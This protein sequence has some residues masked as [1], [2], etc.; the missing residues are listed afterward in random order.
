MDGDGDESSLPRRLVGLQPSLQGVYLARLVLDQPD[1]PACL[2]RVRV[3]VLGGGSWSEP[4]LGDQLPTPSSL[5]FQ[6]ARTRGPA[7]L[8]TT[9]VCGRAG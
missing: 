3:C 9:G 1:S 4:A 6:R 5:Y 7:A 8:P 2:A